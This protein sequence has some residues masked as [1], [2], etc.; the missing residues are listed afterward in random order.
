M[1]AI[2]VA[3]GFILIC[4]G[5]CRPTSAEPTLSELKSKAVSALKRGEIDTAITLFLEV[6]TR[7]PDD[8]VSLTGLAGVY[9]DHKKDFGRAVS[10]FERAIKINPQYD[11]AHLGLATTFVAMGNNAAAIRQFKRTA[12]VTTKP[13]LKNACRQYIQILEEKRG[14]PEKKQ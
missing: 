11:M 10:L 6:T 8:F 5:G 1:K 14:T 2:V 13:M 12:E 4:L 3:V 9:S 7:D